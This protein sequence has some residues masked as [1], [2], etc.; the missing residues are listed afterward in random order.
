MAATPSEQQI[1][2][3]LRQRGFTKAES[4]FRQ[5][6]TTPSSSSSNAVGFS[7]FARSERAGAVDSPEALNKG[8]GG[9]RS[10]VLG[11]LDIFR[12]ELLPVLVPTFVHSYL[13]LVE[14]E[15]KDE[16]AKFLQL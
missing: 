2:N 5:E 6:I 9:L 15:K 4:A 14:N 16:A 10:F 8:Y 3:Y 13:D 1:L 7:Q 12:P 11:S